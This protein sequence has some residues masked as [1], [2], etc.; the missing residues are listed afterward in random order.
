MLGLIGF[1]LAGIAF[2][3]GLAIGAAV[4]AAALACACRLARARPAEGGVR[5]RQRR[6]GR[7]A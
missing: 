5:P 1:A 4:G 7:A 6:A 2:L 3:K